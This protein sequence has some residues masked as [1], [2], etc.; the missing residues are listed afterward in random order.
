MSAP[1]KLKKS[2]TLEIRLPFPT[3]E[4][5]MAQCRDEGVSASEALRGFIEGRLDG[6]AARPSRRLT[7]LVVGAVIAAAVGA[8]AL[9]SLARPLAQ[10][11]VSR[12]AFERLDA[13]HDGV[14]SFD[15]YRHAQ[16]AAR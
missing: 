6:R 9:P 15:E 2:E 5:F 11:L 14:I 7:H 13:N 3:K 1:R 8:V 16:E 4:A 10:D 12:L